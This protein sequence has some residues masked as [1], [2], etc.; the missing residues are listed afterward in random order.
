M[1]WLRTSSVSVFAFLVALAPFA[2]SAQVLDDYASTT[3]Q[4]A[5]A[6]TFD[7]QAAA[8]APASPLDIDNTHLLSGSP[9][10]I[11]SSVQSMLPTTA[12][13][14]RGV[15][16]NL[17]SREESGV[18][19]RLR[20]LRNRDMLTTSR[21]VPT[22]EPLIKPLQENGEALHDLRT[23]TKAPAMLTPHSSIYNHKSVSPAL[24]T[25]SSPEQKQPD[26]YLVEKP[27]NEAMRLSAIGAGNPN[28]MTRGQDNAPRLRNVPNMADRVTTKMLNGAGDLAGQSGVNNPTA[29]GL[30]RRTSVS[31]RDVD[32]TASSNYRGQPLATLSTYDQPIP[33]PTQ[34][35]APTSFGQP[36][37]LT[38]APAADPYNV[39][40]PVIYGANDT[41]PNNAA[42]QTPPVKTVAPFV[43]KK[44]DHSQGMTTPR[45]GSPSSSQTSIRIQQQN[46]YAMAS[47][48]SQMNFKGYVPPRAATETGTLL[49]VPE[50]NTAQNQ[51]E[52]SYEDPIITGMDQNDAPL[53]AQSPNETYGSRAIPLSGTSVNPDR[54][55]G[56][57]LSGDT[58]FGSDKN[59]ASS[60][61]A[62]TATAGFTAGID[63]RLQEASYVGLAL[64][65][66]H[67]SFTNGSFGDLQANSVSVSLYGTTEYATNAYVDGYIGVGY[68]TMESE[69]SIFTGA[70]VNKAKAS[71]DGFQFNGKLESGY[72][73]K[74]AGWKYGPY[75]GF[76]LSYADFG[77]YTES[78]AGNFNL[79]VGTQN[80][81]SA[82]TTLGLGGTHRFDMSN[83][84]TLLP[85]MRMAYNHEFG[86]DTSNIKAAFA[87]LSA[88]GFT[89]KNDKKSR[90][91]LSLNPSL[92]A[93][94]PND[95]SLSA[96][97]EHDFFRNDV[98]ENIFNLAAQYKW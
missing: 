60:T 98:N 88:S 77:K 14:M 66:A 43:Y 30:P 91:W 87:N 58:G 44:I 56:A 8:A 90:D 7:A 71:P 46:A 25:N 45:L 11:N 79:R 6:R 51:T 85:G 12:Y 93:T 54:R 19:S 57:F 76:R 62:K 4:H 29:P 95:W 22:R 28:A 5:V 78:G 38:G 72:D 21:V 55:W 83:G 23:G 2:A 3:D 86:D 40:P 47:A 65:Y 63:Y 80:D 69:R 9:S 75:S 42:P 10:E 35:S 13:N 96:Q 16:N 84:G 26:P 53:L 94:L 73:I 18:M 89:T 97:Y 34:A 49:W 74:N 41:L 70:G 50:S 81:L 92:V 17:A 24:Y 27:Y 33:V 36:L 1:V 31:S 67:S 59:Q 15:A 39:A 68:H 52:S 64:T 82:I 32:K 20:T 61:K 37:P 48:M